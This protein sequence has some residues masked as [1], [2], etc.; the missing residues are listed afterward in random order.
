MGI[1][2]ISQASQLCGV[3]MRTIIN[4]VEAGHIKSYKTVGGHRRI[5][6][7]DLYKFMSDHDIPLP[8]EERCDVRKRILVIDD[9]KI[10][11]KTL[12]MALEEDEHGYEVISAAD[13]FEA[14]LQLAYF[15]P[16]LVILDIM[17]PDI[18]GYEVCK[19]IKLNNET[20]SIKVIVLSA[21]LDAESYA[22]M[23]GYGADLCF[24]KP[25]LLPDLKKEVTK[26]LG[27]EG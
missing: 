8:P 21:Y 7:E 4:W 13:G 11:V 17:M 5:Q 2:T 16:D 27:I 14:G 20:K 12:V 19:R 1:L 24:A 15:K 6:K 26:L 18:N 3:S 23:K 25:L 10:I 22:R 9:D